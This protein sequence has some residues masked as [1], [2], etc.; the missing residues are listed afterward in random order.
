M[1]SLTNTE[2]VTAPEF[3][4]KVVRPERPIWTV[5]LSRSQYAARKQI[6]EL[7][8]KFHGDWCKGDCWLD[9]AG[10]PAMVWWTDKAEAVEA[11]K[12]Y[13]TPEALQALSGIKEAEQASRATDADVTIPVNEGLEYLPYQK[14]GIS[15]M[16]NSFSSTDNKRVILGDSMGLGKTIQV[17][18]VI[19][20]DQSIHSSL[21][22]CPASLKINWAREAQKWLTRPTTVVVANSTKDIPDTWEG[23][24][25]VITNYEKLINASA[26]DPQ[27]VAACRKAANNIAE[28]K[29]KT[30]RRCVRWSPGDGRCRF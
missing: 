1:S 10:V 15:W 9:R 27:V 7:G 28:G 6:K 30:S 11:L 18:G 3:E 22:V 29:K 4:I 14:A 16:V 12:A 23:D 26:A 20:A 8:F 5:Y 17:L 19:N 13:A 25:L 24:L 21:V 2:T